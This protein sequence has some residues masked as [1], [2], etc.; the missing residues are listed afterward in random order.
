VQNPFLW[1]TKSELLRAICEHG[2]AE[3]IRQ[4]VSCAR[5]RE[6]TVMQPHCGVCSQCVD[7]RFGVLAAGLE[8][9]DPETLYRLD[10]LV[11]S[12]PPG[13]PRTMVEA[14]VRT[15][16]E[17]ERLNDAAFFAR[18]G[19]VS[20]ALRFIPEGAEEAGR[21]TFDS[22]QATCRRGL[23]RGRGRHPKE[24]SALRARTLPMGSLLV[25]AVSRRDNVDTFV[26]HSRSKIQRNKSLKTS[27]RRRDRDQL[28]G[29]R[30]T[31]RR[32]KYSSTLARQCAE[33]VTHFWTTSE[34]NTSNR[35]KPGW[36]R[37]IIHSSTV[38]SLLRSEIGGR[39]TNRPRPSFPTAPPFEKK[40]HSSRPRLPG[41]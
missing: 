28:S 29:L 12:L 1:N 9:H 35:S 14:Y 26:S 21:K 22:L 2:C 31:K 30:L 17:I 11:G 6:M 8:A 3:L 40:R 10:L 27:S 39:R 41:N 36:P 32:S 7:R 24:A 20:R 25:L 23:R 19:E 15:A 38:I 5:V 34:S 13:E 37:K 16:S 18:F 4:S 33:R